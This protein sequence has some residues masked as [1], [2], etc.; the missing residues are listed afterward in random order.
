MPWNRWNIV[1]HVSACQRWQVQVLVMYCVVRSAASRGGTTKQSRPRIEKMDC[2]VPRKDAKRVWG[3]S[4]VIP[5]SSAAS[6]SSQRRIMRIMR[7]NLKILNLEILN[8]WIWNLEIWN[9]EC[10]MW[11]HE[12]LKSEMRNAECGIM[13]SEIL[14][15]WNLKCWMW[16]VESWNFEILKS[17]NLWILNP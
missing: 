7:M 4:P 11:N 8:L 10:W 14:K 17:W 3:R 6:A 9:V 15:S 16:N 13:K 12:I 5:A 1:L 2:F